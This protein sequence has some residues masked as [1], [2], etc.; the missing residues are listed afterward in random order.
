MFSLIPAFI[1]SATGIGSVEN[2]KLPYLATSSWRRQD[3]MERMERAQLQQAQMQQNNARMPGF[4]GVRNRPQRVVREV[5]V[6]QARLDTLVSMGFDRSRA[7]IALKNTNN[8]LE[9]ATNNLLTN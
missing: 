1:T 8:D 3:L 2:K 9:Q 4:G 6:D 5:V 7:E